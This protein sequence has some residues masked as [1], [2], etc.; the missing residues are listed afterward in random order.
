MAAL[1]ARA[2]PRLVPLLLPLLLLL[3]ASAARSAASSVPAAPLPTPSE[4]S[5][6]DVFKSGEEGYACYR[7]PVLLRLPDGNLALYAEGRKLN[8]DDMGCARSPPFPRPQRTA[9][10][11]PRRRWWYVAGNDI[12][13]KISKDNG[14]SWSPLHKLY[15]ESTPSKHVTIGN[16]APVVVRQHPCSPFCRPCRCQYRLL[17]FWRRSGP[18]LGKRKRAV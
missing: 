6:V 7:I 14:T 15:G 1:R 13:F 2:A 16:P 12:V 10:D 11:R 5:V 4:D 9:A 18:G 3:L 8:C 17:V